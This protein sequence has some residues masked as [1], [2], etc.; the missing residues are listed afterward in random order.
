MD[1]LQPVSSLTGLPSSE[2]TDVLIR[3]RRSI[4]PRQFTGGDVPK[5]HIERM[6]ENAHWAPNH[7]HTEPWLFK[8]FSGASKDALGKF[9]ADLYLKATPPDEIK[10]G[11]AEGLISKHAQ[12]AWVIAICM[13]R[14]SKAKIPE[15]EEVQAVACAVQ[16]MHLTA[17]A[18]GIGAYWS[19]G[20]MTYHPETA[21]YLGLRPEDKC[22][23]FL[24]VGAL[25]PDSRWPRGSRFAKWEEKVEWME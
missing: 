3:N 6:L 4:F 2:A 22:L 12:C 8:V 23:G 1:N 9:R 21:S 19:S 25:A 20:G 7:G 10:A 5:A 11:K 15:I 18:L 13:Q 14:G 16:N 17:T 24:M